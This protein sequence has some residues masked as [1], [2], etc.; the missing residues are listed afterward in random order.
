MHPV[1]RYGNAQS[2][3]PAISA[4][5]PSHRQSQA[6]AAQ[7]TPISSP[8]TGKNSSILSRASSSQMFPGKGMAQNM[9]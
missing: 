2:A 4:G 5:S 1:T 9:L 6:S 3:T 8:T 7:R